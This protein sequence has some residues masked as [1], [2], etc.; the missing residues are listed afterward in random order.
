M[1]EFNV[2]QQFVI[3]AIPA[4]LAIT[5]H[6]VAH[7]WAALKCGDPT[8]QMLGRLSLNPLKH[9]DPI[10]TVLLP[11]ALFFFGGFIFGWA[12][13]VPVNPRN[14]KNPRPNSAWV[15]FAGPGANLLMMLVWAVVIK[16]STFLTTSSPTAAVVLLNMGYAGVAV[17]VILAV[18]NLIPIPPLDGS[19]IVSSC[20]SPA[21]ERQYSRIE[22]YGIWIMLLLLVTGA[23]SHFIG[24]II[25]L[26]NG[27]VMSLVGFF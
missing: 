21:A 17:N 15:A 8:A 5:L 1:P 6:E 24:P 2:I 27:W 10:G 19:R 13:P 11:I 16:L 7:G 14:F 23:L 26:I 25:G 20:L 12:K 18:I 22:P 9:V 4:L 3:W